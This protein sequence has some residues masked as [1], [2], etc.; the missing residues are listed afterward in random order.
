MH[1]TSVQSCHEFLLRKAFVTF[2]FLCNQLAIESQKEIIRERKFQKL[3]VQRINN[4]NCFDEGPSAAV[5][6]AIE[7]L[8]FNEASVKIIKDSLH[9]SL[10]LWYNNF[11]RSQ[12]DQIIAASLQLKENCDTPIY[13][14]IQP[15]QSLAAWQLVSFWRNTK[16]PSSFMPAR[17]LEKKIR[18]TVR[19]DH[20]TAGGQSARWHYTPVLTEHAKWLPNWCLT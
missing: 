3:I 10:W 1:Q 2:A 17:H 13:I 6:I 15:S 16:F 18:W 20:V 8:C 14:P 12:A 5:A 19:Y 11:K 9:S 4:Y 7:F